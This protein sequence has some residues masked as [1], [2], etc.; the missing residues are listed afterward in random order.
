MNVEKS[1][2][3]ITNKSCSAFGGIQWGASEQTNTFFFWQYALSN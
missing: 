3:L 2:K 1:I